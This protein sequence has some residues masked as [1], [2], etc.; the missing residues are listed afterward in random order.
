LFK[1][2]LPATY[3][4]AD[5]NLSINQLL[6]YYFELYPELEVIT[7]EQNAKL[8]S[9]NVQNPTQFATKMQLSNPDILAEL[10][11]FK[12]YFSF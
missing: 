8:H 9:L 10:N 1:D 11:K 7:L 2:L 3:N 5:V 6:E 12:G 4:M